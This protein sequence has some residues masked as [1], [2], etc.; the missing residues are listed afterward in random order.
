[1]DTPPLQS[2]PVMAR[3]ASVGKIGLF[4]STVALLVMLVLVF[5]KFG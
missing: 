3:R 2:S 1:M 5:G 4:F